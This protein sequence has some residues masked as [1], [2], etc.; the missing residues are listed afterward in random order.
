LI[1][2][3]KSI[4]LSRYLIGLSF[5][6]TLVLGIAVWDI[7][8]WPTDA[9]VYYFDAAIRLPHLEYLS[10]IHEAVDIEIERIYWLHGKEI[11]ILCAS[12]MQWFL[13]DFET[14]R[15]FILV[16]LM[17]VGLSSILIYFIA[18]SYWGRGVGLIS[19][20]AFTASA[21]PYI[22]ILFAKHQPLGLMF[23]LISVVLL[24]NSGRVKWGGVLWVL[25]G[26]C[27][28]LS[29]FSS[30]TSSLY[31][32]YFFA[33]FLHF[34]IKESQESPGLAPLIRR[35][36]IRAGYLLLGLFAVLLYVNWPHPLRNLA[37]F[38]EY[39]RISSAHNHFFY[40]QPF[41]KQ[42]FMHSTVADVRGGVLWILKYF[43][44]IM[45]VL[46]PVYLASLGYLVS[47]AVR[48]RNRSFSITVGAMILLSLSSPVMAEIAQVAQYG[49]NYFPSL[50]GI[51][52]LVGFTV[53][54]LGSDERLRKLSPLK[55]RA[56]TALFAAAALSHGAISAHAFLTDIYPCRMVTTFLSR[57]IAGLNV[58]K[59]Y[60]YQKHSQRNPFVMYLTPSLHDTVRFVPIEY[61]IQPEKSYI[62]VPPTTGNSIYIASTSTYADFDDDVFLNELIRRGKLKDYAVASFK[63]L[64]NSRYW[65]HEEEILSYRS[66]ILGHDFRDN[67]LLG[68]VWLLDG[69]KVFDHLKLNIPVMDYLD[70]HQEGIRKI[71]TRDRKYVFEGYT[72]KTKQTR[73]LTNLLARVYKVGDPRDSLVAY[74]YRLDDQQRVWVPF[75]DHFISEPLPAERISSDPKQGLGVFRFK[76]PL[77]LDP[78]LYFF[79]VYRTGSSDDE[80]HYRIWSETLAMM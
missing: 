79:V 43:F 63:T 72:G 20:F 17:A 46:F 3:L 37:R 13:N 33:A 15:P 30:T 9:R 57:K 39:V 40:N 10:Q 59:I 54:V 42:W 25:T 44:L 67:E 56:V 35:G 18:R 2:R 32:P 74:V 24:Q 11:F 34:H 14:L 47:V 5:L 51:I 71:G 22:Y 49:A 76:P 38:F 7:N 6:I 36:L 62:L 8:F 31:F 29:F 19:Y 50:I 60:T 48:R 1:S 16:C 55:R 75:S 69:K 27:L 45:P 21:W 66:L 80:N 58:P 64:A 70:L 28:G 41:L 68:R 23:F 65:L 53:P 52:M 78:G 12:M 26:I 73:T 61:I 4:P 77:R